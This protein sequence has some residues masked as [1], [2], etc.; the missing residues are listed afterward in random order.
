[1]KKPVLEFFHENR[2]ALDREIASGHHEEL[3][4]LLAGHPAEEF[5]IRLAEI[6]RYCD[7]VLHG[8]YIQPDLDKLCG[9]LRDKLARKRS[10]IL[11][12]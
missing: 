7:V 9:L 4:E 3:Q 12:N 11:L 8:D 5:E 2:I 10:I 1:M 6:A